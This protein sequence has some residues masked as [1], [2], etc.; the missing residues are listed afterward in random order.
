HPRLLS[1]P[2]PAG[3]PQPPP[4]LP[5]PPPPPPRPPP[6]TTVAPAHPPPKGA[7][8]GPPGP[9]PPAAPLHAAP[10]ACAPPQ[11]PPPTAEPHSPNPLPTLRPGRTGGGTTPTTA[12]LL[13]AGNSR[14]AHSAH[15]RRP[16][17]HPALPLPRAP[18]T[19]QSKTG[20]APPLRPA[21]PQPAPA[22]R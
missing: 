7:A 22:G 4:P 17:P 14:A 9:P 21:G 20:S 11:H 5:A 13:P 2:P 6:R 19:L 16:G 10:P 15:P 3:R 1:P 12:G 8:G 18:P